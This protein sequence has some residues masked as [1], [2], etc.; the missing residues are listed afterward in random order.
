MIYIATVNYFDDFE[1]KM[2]KDTIVVQAHSYSEAMA[3]IE[4]SFK[5]SIE[6]IESISD[7]SDMTIIHLGNGPLVDQVVKLLCQENGY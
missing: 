4:A 6:S 7:I 3:A 2:D 1:N 5:S